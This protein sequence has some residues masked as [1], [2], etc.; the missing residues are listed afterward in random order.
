MGPDGATLIIEVPHARDALIDL[1]DCDS[2]K[3]FS[4]WS[5]HLILHTAESLR[6]FL[7]ETGFRVEAI[8]FIQ[9]YPVSNHLHWLSR[10]MP[11]GHNKWCFLDT[12]DLRNAYAA[13]LGK[14]GI[15]DTLIAIASKGKS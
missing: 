10:G 6:I 2:F 13:S 9:R 3:K 4:F 1:Y 8:N 12:P 7:Q 11:G 14:S 5:Q 15:S